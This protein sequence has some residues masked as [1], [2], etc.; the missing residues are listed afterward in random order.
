MHPTKKLRELLTRI[1]LN[2]VLRI[3]PRPPP[4]NLRKILL[5]HQGSHI[6][7]NI[8]LN[9]NLMPYVRYIDNLDLSF[10]GGVPYRRG[11]SVSPTV[12]LNASLP[13]V[14]DHQRDEMSARP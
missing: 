14:V 11:R 9:I 10:C 5:L 12:H 4:K 13:L 1:S 2:I 7:L 3:I 6:R 8:D